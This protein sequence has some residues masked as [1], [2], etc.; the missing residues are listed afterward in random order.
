MR[1]DRTKNGVPLTEETWNSITA[2]AR[3]VG[4]DDAAVANAAR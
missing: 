4:I 1:A 3:S 2:T